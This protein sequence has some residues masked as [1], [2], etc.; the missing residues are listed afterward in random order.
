MAKL[1]KHETYVLFSRWAALLFILGALI[2][3]YLMDGTSLPVGVQQSPYSRDGAPERR[4]DAKYYIL[5]SKWNYRELVLHYRTHRDDHM[6]EE[7]LATMYGLEYSEGMSYEEIYPL[8]ARP[9]YVRILWCMGGL[10]VLS[11]VLPP[12]LIRYPIN[13]G[14]PFLA[15]RLCRSRRK[16]VLTKILVLDM[17]VIAISLLTTLIKIWAFAGSIISQTSLGYVLYTILLRLLMAMA[18]MSVPIWLAF[19]IRN[20][21]GLIVV[22][23]LY[24]VLC[25]GLNV[26]ACGSDKLLPVPIPAYLHGLRPIWQQGGPAGWIGYAAAVSVV[27]IVLFIALSVRAFDRECEQRFGAWEADQSLKAGN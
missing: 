23:T 1:L 11:A 27:W 16:A 9:S 22:E 8:T 26:A 21:K 3:C 20:L 14:V 10:L 4:V 18:V 17:I 2:G 13:T 15:A 12:V 5:K 6:T 24:G 25:Y 19:A 7:K